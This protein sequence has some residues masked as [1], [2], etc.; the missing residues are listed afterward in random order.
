MSDWGK[1][2]NTELRR[3]YRSAESVHKLLTP[4]EH[5]VSIVCDML[6]KA[7]LA[8]IHISNKF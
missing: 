5:G 1:G 8:N 2:Y 6:Q 7:S 3:I 4:K